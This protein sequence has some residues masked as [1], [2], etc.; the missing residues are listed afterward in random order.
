MRRSATFSVF[1]GSI[2]DEP[3]GIPLSGPFVRKS[4]EAE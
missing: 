3:G 4:V 2:H 1:D